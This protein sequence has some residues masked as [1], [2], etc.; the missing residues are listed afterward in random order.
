MVIYQ[1]YVCLLEGT[2]NAILLEKDG[3]FNKAV[4]FITPWALDPSG[5]ICVCGC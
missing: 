5:T 3:G 2:T 1:V 4:R